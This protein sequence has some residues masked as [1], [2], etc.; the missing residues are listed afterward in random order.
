MSALGRPG[1][2]HADAATLLRSR[3]NGTTQAA[4]CPAPTSTSG[5]TV[6]HSSL[7]RRQGISPAGYR[8]GPC[9]SKR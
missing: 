5:G 2:A 9:R 3:T 4:L 6:A 7:A 8:F 1:G